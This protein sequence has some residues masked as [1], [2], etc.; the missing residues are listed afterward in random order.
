M[1]DF[2]EQ[3]SGGERGEKVGT[4]KVDRAYRLPEGGIEYRRVIDLNLASFAEVY[5]DE[6]GIESAVAQVD[7]PTETL[8]VVAHLRAALGA[9]EGERVVAFL[10]GLA[11]DHGISIS[12]VSD[13]SEAS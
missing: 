1:T 12:D 9:D 2:T 11:L 13:L 7:I 5:T 8:R 10:D 3:A 6:L 4:H